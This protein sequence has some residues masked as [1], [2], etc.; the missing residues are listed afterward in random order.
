MVWWKVKKK[1][2]HTCSLVKE[3]A[4][5]NSIYIDHFIQI[6]IQM[7]QEV[8]SS[9]LHHNGPPLHWINLLCGWSYRTFQRHYSN[10][11][12][13]GALDCHS[14]YVINEIVAYNAIPHISAHV[15]HFM[16]PVFTRLMFWHCPS[17]HFK[18]LPN[19]DRFMSYC[20]YSRRYA[21]Y[22]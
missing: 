5:L 3:L 2:T 20:Q 12:V 19:A 4:Y 17:P 9:S 7:I 22:I 6:H 18:Q 15:P 14:N 1:K 21:C 13:T 8:L 10:L 16:L 11:R